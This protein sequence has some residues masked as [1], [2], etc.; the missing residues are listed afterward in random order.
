M[1]KKEKCKCS[2]FE[3]I[4]LVISFSI[5]AVIAIYTILENNRD[6]AIATHN[7]IQDLEIADNQ[8]K[9]S[10]LRD[11]QK[12]ISKLI[13]KYGPQ[14]NESESI[15]LLASFATL[16]TMNQLDPD[17]RNFLV[18]LLYDTELITCHSISDKVPIAFELANLT[19]L[20]LVDG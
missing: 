5:P 20:C 1:T 12:T 18:H 15:I 8:Q 7:R 13:E 14:L 19:N 16:S 9:D 2:C 6:L 11:Y 17:R 10:I 4:Q 3:W